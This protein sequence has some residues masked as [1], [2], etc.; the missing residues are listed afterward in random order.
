MQL[1]N[2][3][4]KVGRK[5]IIDVDRN[6]LNRYTECGNVDIASLYGKGGGAKNYQRARAAKRAVI[7]ICKDFV[8]SN[9]WKTL[10]RGKE[11][12]GREKKGDGERF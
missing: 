7:K 6:P 12:D 2:L 10:L 4:T 9:V 1:D 11:S 3:Q 5:L 8:S